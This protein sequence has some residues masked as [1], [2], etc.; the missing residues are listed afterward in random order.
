MIREL[1]F[2]LNRSINWFQ[3]EDNASGKLNN[4]WAIFWYCYIFLNNGLCLSPKVSLSKNIGHDGSG[5]HTV[6]NNNFLN[7]NLNHE[8]IIDYPSK[9]EEE[10]SCY[11]LSREYLRNQNSLRSRI[12]RKFQTIL[13]KIQRKFY[14]GLY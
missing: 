14:A 4:T 7:E 10:K 6:L 11:L 5:V 2:G 8:K 12:Y 1:D 9:I 13:G 3:I